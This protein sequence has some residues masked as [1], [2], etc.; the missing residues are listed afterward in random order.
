MKLR[1][2][3][4]PTSLSGV[5]ASSTLLLIAVL[6]TTACATA[7]PP[8][9]T[10]ISSTGDIE[11]TTVEL[12]LRVYGYAERF[13]NEAA[14]AADRIMEATDDVKI[15]RNA[16][17]WKMNA[18]VGV[19]LTAFALDPLVALFDMWVL[20]VQ[21]RQ[22]FETGL[23]KDVFG[24]HQSIAIET[25][26]QLEREADQLVRSISLSGDISDLQREIEA[27]A[28]ANPLEGLSLVRKTATSEFADQLGADRT[29]GLAVLGDLSVQVGDLSERI[30]YYAAGL[31]EQFRWQSELLLLDILS[32]PQVT[33]FLGDIGS[34]DEAAL[35][36]ADFAD[37]LPALI[38]LQATA[39]IAA[40]NSEIAASLREVDRQRIETLEVLTG[41]RIAVME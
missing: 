30:K 26:R 23:G 8:Q 12:R 2:P 5:R 37:S 16:L 3:R 13:V 10:L 20:A 29:S 34:V 21:M 39:A 6:A 40:L 17:K 7:P 22:F 38:D 41:E 33:G 28:L 9:S 32:D 19:Q 25:A 14:I 15:S 36:L 27:Y 35:R 31:P 4:P 11:M 24:P 1:M 18:V